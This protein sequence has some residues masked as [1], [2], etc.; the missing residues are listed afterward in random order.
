MTYWMGNI[1]QTYAIPRSNTSTAR[2]TRRESFG[3][4]DARIK[5][6]SYQHFKIHNFCIYVGRVTVYIQRKQSTVDSNLGNRDMPKT[7]LTARS[8]PQKLDKTHDCT[9]NKQQRLWKDLTG[10]S[11]H[12]NT[13]S[14]TSR[15]KDYQQPMLMTAGPPCT[16]YCIG[17]DKAGENSDTGWMFFHGCGAS[18]GDCT[19]IMH[20]TGAVRQRTISEQRA[21]GR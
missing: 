3:F 7:H 1:G 6:V 2:Q 9:C 14:K 21:T 13:F 19:A 16:Y 20:T 4:I 11:C 10:T 5:T 8:M 12:G 17:G 15:Y 18:D